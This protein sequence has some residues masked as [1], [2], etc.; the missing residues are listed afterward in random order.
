MSAG[1]DAHREGDCSHLCI[2]CEREDAYEPTNIEPCPECKAVKHGN[3][4]GITWDVVADEEA[5]C[6]CAERGHQ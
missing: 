2:Y 1:L 4:D 5:P 6:P 3:C